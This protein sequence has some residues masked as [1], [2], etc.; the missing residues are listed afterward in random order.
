MNGTDPPPLRQD[1]GQSYPERPLSPA[2]RGE[3]YIPILLTTV[4]QNEVTA[5]TSEEGLANQN[6][7][8]HPPPLPQARPRPAETAP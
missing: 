8:A 5:V 3:G 4:W 7:S 1:T 6:A 2:G